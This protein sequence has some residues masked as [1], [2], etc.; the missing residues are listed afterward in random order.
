[1]NLPMPSCSKPMPQWRKIAC[2][3]ALAVM[4]PFCWRNMGAVNLHAVAGFTLDGKWSASLRGLSL[5]HGGLPF[6]LL[7][8]LKKLGYD[9]CA[10][11][12]WS[13]ICL[14]LGLA[15]QFLFPPGGALLADPR[16]PRNINRVFGMEDM[17]PQLW[18]DPGTCVFLWISAPLMVARELV[19]LLR[20]KAMA[21]LRED[22]LTMGMP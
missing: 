8:A 14:G 7:C 17:R 1:M 9:R 10:L 19:L 5:F 3:V 21:W 20:E 22:G 18:V 4:L 16:T 6:L 13:V 11:A 12:G 15:S 2:A